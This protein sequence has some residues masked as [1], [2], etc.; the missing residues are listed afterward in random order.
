MRYEYI[1]GSAIKAFHL[2]VTSFIV[3]KCLQFIYIILKSNPIMESSLFLFAVSK[4][5]KINI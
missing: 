2:I 1:K 5:N 3:H 4:K